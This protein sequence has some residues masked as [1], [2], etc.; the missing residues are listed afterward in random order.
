[1]YIMNLVFNLRGNEPDDLKVFIK[2]EKTVKY[3]SAYCDSA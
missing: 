2:G 3:N 1:M